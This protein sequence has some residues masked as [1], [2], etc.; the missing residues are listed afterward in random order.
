MITKE[1]AEFFKAISIVARYGSDVVLRDSLT[2]L[3]NRHFFREVAE[4]EIARAKRYQRPLTLVFLDVDGL[5]KINDTYGHQEG[6]RILKKVGQV[7]LNNCRKSDIPVRWGGDEFLMLLPETGV[8]EAKNLVERILADAKG[9]RLSYGLAFW[10][11]DFS[12]LEDFV[13]EV[14]KKMYSAKKVK[15]K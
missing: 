10:K 6:D 8:E 2:G 3:Y 4:K 14:D 15:K 12:S 5:K 1:I 9:V 11:E 7:I 13:D